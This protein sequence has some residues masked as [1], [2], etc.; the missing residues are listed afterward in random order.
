M[1]KLILGLTLAGG[2]ALLGSQVQAACTDPDLDAVRDEIL[3][4]CGGDDCTNQNHGHHVSCVAHKVKEAVDDGRLDVNCKGKVVRCG[5]RSTCG[6][7]GFV[8]CAICDPGT[9]TANLCDDGLTF[10]DEVTPCPPVLRRCS[11]KSS[12]DR[13]NVPASAPEGTTVVVGSGS[14]CAASCVVDD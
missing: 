2:V 9:C 10:C 12:A 11:T 1:R 4:A 13:C 6:K 5:A 3:A 8:T 14:C 7:P